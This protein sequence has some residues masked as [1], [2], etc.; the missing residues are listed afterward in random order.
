MEILKTATF[1]DNTWETNEY[2]SKR[3]NLQAMINGNMKGFA[4][5]PKAPVIN[6]E[7]FI[8]TDAEKAKLKE[9]KAINKRLPKVK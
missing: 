2:V 7:I 5:H 4:Y 1:S 8:K 9:Y 6:R 3:N